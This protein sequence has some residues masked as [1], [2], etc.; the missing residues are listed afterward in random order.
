MD[1]NLH[2]APSRPVVVLA[3]AT[4]APAG[5]SVE[6]VQIPTSGSSTTTTTPPPKPV[7]YSVGDRTGCQDVR[8][9]LSADLPPAL[10]DDKQDGPKW[11]TRI[12]P[13]RND[14]SLVVLKIQYWE[15]TEDVTG[16]QPGAKRAEEDFLRRGAAREK[17]TSLTVGSDARWKREDANGCT[18]EILDENAVLTAGHSNNKTLTPGNTE[19]CR[20]PM[21]TLAKQFFTAV[22]P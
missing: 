20:T 4:L 6:P 12:C 2:R 18:I 13:F 10:P 8:Q 19:E 9:Q 11:S 3:A 17:D 16:V 7:K 15:T 22:Q 21:R 5:C 14:D 1:A